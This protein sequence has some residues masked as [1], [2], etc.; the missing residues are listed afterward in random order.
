MD[1]SGSVIVD[2]KKIKPSS[3][4]FAKNFMRSGNAKAWTYPEALNFMLD[5]NWLWFHDGGRRRS[6]CYDFWPWPA[7]TLKP[8]PRVASNGMAQTVKTRGRYVYSDEQTR[9]ILLADATMNV[10]PNA[11][12]LFEIIRVAK[13]CSIL[14]CRTASCRSHIQTLA[15]AKVPCQIKPA[16]PF[17][18]Q[19]TLS[20]FDYWW[21][22]S[23]Q[24]CIGCW[25]ATRALSVQCVGRE[26]E[27]IHLF[28][29]NLDRATLPTNYW[30]RLAVL[31]PLA[32]IDWGWKTCA[33]SAS[34][35]SIREIVNMAAIAVVDAQM[36][37]RT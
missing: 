1:L 19:R 16:R 12:E 3:N 10:N 22:Y 28:S 32:L 25:V 21:R 8:L 18:W 37:E 23:G 31:K 36:H 14:W 27:Q 11:Q 29:P 35:C 24:R 9:Y 33:H 30:W 17:A 15:A 2:P 6:R 20:W 4:R 5:L 7:I 13:R 34:G 26:R